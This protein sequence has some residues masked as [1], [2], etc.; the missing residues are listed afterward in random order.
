MLYG[1]TDAY[2]STKLRIEYKEQICAPNYYSS[3]SYEHMSV[4][5]QRDAL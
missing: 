2:R 5:M 3:E 4:I 1:Y